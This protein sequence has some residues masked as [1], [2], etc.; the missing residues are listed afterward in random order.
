MVGAIM[1]YK[2]VIENANIA[3]KSLSNA[4]EETKI[5]ALKAMSKALKD[6][7]PK[8]LEA[9]KLD[10]DNASLLMPVMRKRLALTE[11]KIIAIANDV[12]SVSNLDSVCNKVLETIN[13]P[14][15]LVIKKVA[16]PFGV[17]LAIFESRPNVCVDIASLC[18]KTSNVC[19]LRGG[20]EAIN[21]NTCLVSI[22]REAIAPFI[23]ENSVSLITETDRAIVNELIT[24]KDKIDL[25]VPRGGK[26]LID[27]IVNNSLV[28]VIETGAGTC[29]IYVDKNASLDMA[30]NI[31][32]NGKLSNPAVCNALEC[33]L[34]HEN[35]YKEY[36]DL[37]KS[38]KFDKIV[39][40]HG[41]DITKEYFNCDSV[42]SYY[43]EFDDLEVNIK[44]VKSLDEAISHI[45]TYGTKHSEVVVTNDEAVAQKFLSEVDAACVYWNASSRFSD[46]GC[47]GFCAELGISTGK[48]HARGPMGLKEMMTYKY[49]IFGNGQIR[50]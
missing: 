24:M 23:D 16:V 11:E 2:D 18:I 46:G 10:L 47:F 43:K 29:H 38:Q 7:V 49:E 28:P 8:I 44:V 35:V 20:K 26:G 22:I 13:R 12:I 21:T 19:V 50:K 32:L 42:S 15:G 45:N 31:T 5:E 9:N 33:I 6:N 34:V 39:N 36:F 40:V 17:I 41:C 25:V 3:K 37:L 1:N 4:S 14:N 30:V 27:N 48:M